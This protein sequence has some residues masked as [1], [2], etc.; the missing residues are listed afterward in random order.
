MEGGE[1]PLLRS[2]VDRMSD[3]VCIV[4]KEGKILY[5][6]QRLRRQLPEVTEEKTTIDD[7]KTSTG[8]RNNERESGTAGRREET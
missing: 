5:I 7:E 3:G 8:I 6:N 1:W 4:T 2:V